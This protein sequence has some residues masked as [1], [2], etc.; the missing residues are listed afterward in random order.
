MQRIVGAPRRGSRKIV[1]LAGAPASGKS[2][3]ADQIAAEIPS[4]RVVPMDGFHLSNDVLKARGLLRLK[5]APQTFDAE[6]FVDLVSRLG[7]AVD[8]AYPTFDRT[9][10]AVIADGGHVPASCSTVIVEGNY[11]LLKQGP[12]S[13]LPDLFDLTVLLDVSLEVLRERLV[14]RWLDHGLNKDAALE[15]ANSNDIPN[16]GTVIAGS[17]PADIVIVSG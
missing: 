14:Q 13:R 12:W 9:T 16:A 7:D 17:G 1:G 11:L 15:R 5:G 4:A 6:G 10:D 2:T 3:L 8:V